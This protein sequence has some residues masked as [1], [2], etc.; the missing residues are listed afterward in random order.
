MRSVTKPAKTIP[1]NIMATGKYFRLKGTFLFRWNIR[2]SDTPRIAHKI[3][4]TGKMLSGFI[5]VL[6]FSL[7]Q[8]THA[9]AAPQA[10]RPVLRTGRDAQGRPLHALV[11]TFCLVLLVLSQ[12]LIQCL[13]S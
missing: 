12:L 4:K 3:M 13:F 5:L 6:P 10:A 2:N 7:F 9:S 8:P 11:K 1:M